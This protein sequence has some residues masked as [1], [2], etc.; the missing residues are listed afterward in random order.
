M[1]TPSIEQRLAMLEREIAE[2]KRAGKNW[3]RTVGM[4]TGNSEMQKLFEQAMKLRENDRAKA[5]GTQGPRRRPK[6]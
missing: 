1:S 6:A 2:L 5:R 3:R 4:F